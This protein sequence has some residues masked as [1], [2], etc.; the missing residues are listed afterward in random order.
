MGCNN[1]CSLCQPLFGMVPVGK[2]DE[3]GDRISSLQV[4]YANAVVIC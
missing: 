4:S 3:G 2:A 1:V